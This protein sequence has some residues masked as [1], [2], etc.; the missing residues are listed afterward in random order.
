MIRN[1]NGSHSWQIIVNKESLMLRVVKGS[2]DK[3][4]NPVVGRTDFFHN[5]YKLV[6][7]NQEQEFSQELSH[8]RIGRFLHVA[9]INNSCVVTEKLHS[10]PCPRRAPGDEQDL[11]LQLM[12]RLTIQSNGEISDPV[13]VSMVPA[14]S[15]EASIP[16]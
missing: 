11:V 5:G 3:I 13:V 15:Q 9:D 16:A 4:S 10:S 8:L 6:L 7:H 2:G 12:D 14:T 1:I